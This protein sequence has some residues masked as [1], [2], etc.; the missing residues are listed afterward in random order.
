[1]NIKLS[2]FSYL[3]FLFTTFF[4]LKVENRQKAACNK[5]ENQKIAFQDLLCGIMGL[6]IRRI[7]NLQIFSREKICRIFQKLEISKNRSIDKNKLF[8]HNIAQLTSSSSELFR[9][10]PSRTLEYC[11][12]STRQTTYAIS[13]V[14]FRSTRYPN[15]APLA[16]SQ[17]QCFRFRR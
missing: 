1:M 7:I 2:F 3:K 17:N 5:N 8:L 16:T 11:L 6:K 4:L 9:C 14:Q 12:T 13:P 10:T 15:Y